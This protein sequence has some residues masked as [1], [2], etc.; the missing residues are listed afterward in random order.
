MVKH[1][2][3]GAEDPKVPMVKGTL[4]LPGPGGGESTRLPLGA[5]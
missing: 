5:E 4:R 1:V 2:A 3:V